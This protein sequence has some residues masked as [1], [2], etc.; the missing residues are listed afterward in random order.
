MGCV[1]PRSGPPPSGSD[2]RFAG[3]RTP[4]SPGGPGVAVPR[5]PDP[6]RPRTAAGFP[7]SPE[8]PD[9][10]SPSADLRTGRAEP[11]PRRPF[12]SRS[13]VPRAEQKDQQLRSMPDGVV[14]THAGPAGQHGQMATEPA[15]AERNGTRSICAAARTARHGRRTSESAD[16]SA[17][18]VRFSGRR[19]TQLLRHLLGMYV[20]RGA[21]MP[22]AGC[23][24]GGQ[25]GPRPGFTASPFV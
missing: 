11:G 14:R 10:I 13:A 22:E 16:V 4:A 24:R 5:Y 17:A 21:H 20:T 9:A 2:S 12:R 25:R 3:A 15:A 8:A 23:R 6:G 19:L 7:N 18:L 1:G